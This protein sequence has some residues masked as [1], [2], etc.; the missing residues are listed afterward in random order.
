MQQPTHRVIDGERIELSAKE[1]QAVV[2]RRQAASPSL[3]EAKSEKISEIKEQA[4]NR[5]T[6]TDWYII[7][8]Q[9]I[10]EAVPQ[11]VLDHRA[12]IRSQSEVFEADVNNLDSL[13]SVRSYSFTYPDPP[14]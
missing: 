6:E 4:Y 14:V 9:E 7:R 3:S 12:E 5:L 13:S 2:E 11:A 1:Q 8:R 10:G